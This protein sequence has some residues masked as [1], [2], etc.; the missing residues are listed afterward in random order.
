MTS[1]EEA[2]LRQYLLHYHEIENDQDFES[3]YTRRYEDA[4]AEAYHKHTVYLAH[5]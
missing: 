2:V 4:A 1:E 5:M 3:W